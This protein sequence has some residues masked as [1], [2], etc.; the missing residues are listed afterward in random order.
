MRDCLDDVWYLEVPPEVREERLGW[1]RWSFGHEPAA[2]EEW[3]RTVDGRNGRT[4]E[5]SRSRADLLVNLDVPET[6]RGADGT[7]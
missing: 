6:P 5:R 4:V 7:G 1:G 2:A 3:V